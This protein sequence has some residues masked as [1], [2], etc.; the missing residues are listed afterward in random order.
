MSA[1]AFIFVY[2]MVRLLA[3]Y[4][5]NRQREKVTRRARER[6]LHKRALERNGYTVITNPFTGEITACF[7]GRAT[8]AGGNPTSIV[9]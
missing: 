4:Y 3:R 6:Y 9:G 1:V 7:K 8:P 5:A 2:I